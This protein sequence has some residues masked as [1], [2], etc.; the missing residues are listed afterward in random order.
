MFNAVRF[1]WLPMCHIDVYCYVLLCIVMYCSVP[2]CALIRGVTATMPDGNMASSED[3][4]C[5]SS[6][7]TG[8]S[9]EPTHLDFE[10]IDKEKDFFISE[11]EDNED[12]FHDCESSPHP[13]HEV[14]QRKPRLKQHIE[15]VVLNPFDTDDTLFQDVVIADEPTPGS[16]DK[17]PL[18][19]IT[20]SSS[21]NGEKKKR[22]SL[23]N[24]GPGRQ[25]DDECKYT[26]ED[27][28]DTDDEPTDA[29]FQSAMDS[30]VR[31][32]SRAPVGS[33]TSVV[34]DSVI[35]RDTQSVHAVHRLLESFAESAF[36]SHTQM[37]TENQLERLIK[38]MKSVHAVMQCAAL[39]DTC[40]RRRE[41]GAVGF[42]FSFHTWLVK[43]LIEVASLSGDVKLTV[44]CL[45]RRRLLNAHETL[46]KLLTQINAAKSAVVVGDDDWSDLSVGTSNASSSDTPM[47]PSHSSH[48]PAVTPT[49][50]TTSSRQ[51]SS[52]TSAQSMKLM[53]QIGSTADISAISKGQTYR[54]EAFCWSTRTYLKNHTHPAS[55]TRKRNL[56][57]NASCESTNPNH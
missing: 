17:K 15:I 33:T 52:L 6:D 28:S 32:T 50:T 10:L 51:S 53:S 5:P 36:L 47:T 12:A 16:E 30:S 24:W 45:M 13:G 44:E 39:V 21:V 35:A 26:D 23:I 43:V 11:N 3:L 18:E 4:E 25:F 34:S 55:S 46:C 49:S 19:C 14:Q 31:R 57:P 2:R 37:E 22:K 42:S 27:D 8:L 1:A 20:E 9:V 48:R 7:T 38:P 41:R 56:T 29:G 54:S 40:D